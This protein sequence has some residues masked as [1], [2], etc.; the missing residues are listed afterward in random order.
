M[1]KTK[2]IIATLVAC[3]LFFGGVSN[4][5]AQEPEEEEIEF[6]ITGID[7]TPD[8]PGLGKGPVGMPTAWLSGHIVDFHGTH[9]DYVLRIVDSTNTVVYSTPV[10]SSQTQVWLPTYLVGIYRIELLWNGWVFYGYI[11]L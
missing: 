4:V 6:S 10:P 1:K 7:P 3:L 8:D 2:L 9:A 5:S 11:T